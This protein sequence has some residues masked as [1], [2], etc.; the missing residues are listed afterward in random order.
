MEIEEMKNT[1]STVKVQ[2]LLLNQNNFCFTLYFLQSTILRVSFCR[3]LFFKRTV[4]CITKFISSF[5]GWTQQSYWHK[6]AFKL[7]TGMYVGGNGRQLEVAFSGDFTNNCCLKTTLSAECFTV[8]IAICQFSRHCPVCVSVA[9]LWDWTAKPIE[10]IDIAIVLM[11]NLEWL[12]S[13]LDLCNQDCQI[14]K[15]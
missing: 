3:L 5:W 9:L 4:L 13:D 15:A 2:I 12:M 11:T 6:D 7:G 8:V 14:K 10:I 1:N